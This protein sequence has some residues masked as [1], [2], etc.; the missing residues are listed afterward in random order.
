MNRASNGYHHIGNA[1]HQLPQQSGIGNGHHH[2]SAWEEDMG[3]GFH[4]LGI[5][6]DIPRLESNAPLELGR[7]DQIEGSRKNKREIEKL[8][9]NV[10]RDSENITMRFATLV[11]AIYRLLFRNHIPLEE[12]RLALL[13][14]GCHRNKPAGQNV[15]MFSNTTSDIAQAPDLAALIQGLHNYS[16]WFNYRLLKYVATHFGGEEGK[17]L[18]AEYEEDLRGYFENLIAYQCPQFSLT[19]GIP[20]GCEQL[21]VKVEWDYRTCSAQ[22]VAHFQATL[23]DVLDLEPYVFQ[24]RSIEEGCVLFTWAV[25]AT[26]ALHILTET[27]SHKSTLKEW[28]VVYVRILGRCIDIQ[29]PKKWHP[30]S[31]YYTVLFTSG[32]C[33]SVCQ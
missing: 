6:D 27:L 25:P 14:L 1:Y 10:I 24:L 32:L 20:Q 19:K 12:V 21:D 30:V 11:L 26:V 4:Q 31:Y 5:R 16:S 18:I 9:Y 22:D 17:T 8:R 15:S 13:F 28:K 2:L 3:N 29:S 23:S 33:I 7:F